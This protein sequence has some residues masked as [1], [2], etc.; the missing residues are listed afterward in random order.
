M[1]TKL[2]RPSNGTEGDWFTDKHCMRCIHCDPDPDGAKQ[3]KILCASLVYSVH[4]AGYPTEWVYDEKEQ[5]TCTSY[6]HWDW[7]EQGNPD[8]P[9]N[10][11]APIAVG[12]N[13]LSLPFTLKGSKK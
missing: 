6:Q 8:D 12:E 1:N 7:E 4:E 13:Q 5:P 10:H 9:D 3:C 2:Y 11:N